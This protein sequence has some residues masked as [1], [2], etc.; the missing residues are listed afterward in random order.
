MLARS[1]APGARRKPSDADWLIPASIFVAIQYCFAFGV[2]ERIAYPLRPPVDAYL[3]IALALAGLAA[4]ARVLFFIGRMYLDGEANPTQRLKRFVDDYWRSWLLFFAGFLLAA[5]QIGALTWLKAMLPF[6]VPFWAD[7]MLAAAD[8]AILGTDAWRLFHPL[9]DPVDPIIDWGYASWFPLKTCVLLWALSKTP[10]FEKSRALLS[11]FL[12]IG[13]FGVVGQY[14]LSSAGPIF[15]ARLGLG[16]HFKDLPFSAVALRGSDYLWAARQD[17]HSPI[18]GGISAMPSVHVASSVWMAFAC[19]ALLPRICGLLAIA[20]AVLI[21]V[22]SMYLGWHYFVDAAAGV[23]AGCAAWG[24]AGYYL[25]EA[26]PVSN[27]LV[28]STITRLARVKAL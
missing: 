10:C 20:F 25:R 28:A 23:V 11:Y 26:G 14:A 9:L 24:L 3:Y 6:A 16:D 18:G 21:F 8:R 17:I 5:A 13:L 7:P 4:T 12:M 2:S 1:D 22:G 19:W 15:Y 27:R